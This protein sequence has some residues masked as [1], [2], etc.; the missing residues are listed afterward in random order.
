M[1]Y[2]LPQSGRG[3]LAGYISG[4]HPATEFWQCC[5]HGPRG[6]ISA[7][8]LY[9]ALWECSHPVHGLEPHSNPLGSSVPDEGV[10][11]QCQFSSP[12]SLAWPQVPMTEAQPWADVPVHLQGGDSWSG[13]LAEPDCSL[14]VSPSPLLEDGGAGPLQSGWERLQIS[15]EHFTFHTQYRLSTYMHHVVFAY[16]ISLLF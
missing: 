13:F 6:A 5:F 15:N 2:T 9:P 12:H 4:I 8:N 7:D 1:Y 10:L 16:C 14:W 3:S 11:R